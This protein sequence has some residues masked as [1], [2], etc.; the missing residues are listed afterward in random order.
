MADEI[1]TPGDGQIRAMIIMAGD[2][3]VSC[4]NSKRLARAFK[5]LE[6]LIS[7]DCF[8]NDTGSIAD[9]ILPATTFL[10]REDFAMSTVVYNSIPFIN[11]STPVV[12]PLAEEKQVW[13]IFNL[14]SE[15]I[16]LPTLGNEPRNISKSL[17]SK[18]DLDKI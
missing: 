4:P 7:I 11:Y 9:Y 12:K 17:L 18:E 3:L 15:K 2:P 5:D 14:L 8:I 16:G 6:L 10:E 13:E 1:L